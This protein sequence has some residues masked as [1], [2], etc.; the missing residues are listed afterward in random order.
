MGP[1][2]EE[3]SYWGYE[4]QENGQLQSVLSFHNLPPTSQQPQNSTLGESFHSPPPSSENILL[5]RYL[6]NVPVQTQG[7][8]SP[9]TKLAKCSEKHTRK[10]QQTRQRLMASGRQ[11]LLLV[12]RISSDHNKISL[13]PQEAQMLLLWT[14]LLWCRPAISHPS[15]LQIFTVYFCWRSPSIR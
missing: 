3:G 6:K 8:S 15:T 5:S 7:E 2:K 13:W 11:D 1:R 4:E 12:T 9:F 10:M 14:I